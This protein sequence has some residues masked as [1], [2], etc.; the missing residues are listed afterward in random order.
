M[1]VILAVLVASATAVPGTG[2]TRPPIRQK[3]HF[4]TV[5]RRPP[6]F[7]MSIRGRT[8]YGAGAALRIGPV[9]RREAV[10]DPAR[11][12]GL[13]VAAGAPDRVTV[14]KAAIAEW[15]RRRP[16]LMRPMYSGRDSA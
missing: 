12:H 11:L 6:A 5:R 3:C 15:K 8:K 1:R 10:T 4:G 14:I 16:L 9:D 7:R 2:A 13:V